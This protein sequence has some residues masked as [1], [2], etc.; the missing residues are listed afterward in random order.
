[1]T[2]KGYKQYKV[3]RKE[4]LRNNMSEL[5]VALADIEERLDVIYRLK[6][7]YGDSEELVL[8]YRDDAI[9][10]L[11]EMGFLDQDSEKLSL[12]FVFK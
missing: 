8:K 2:A 10:E 1:M 3:L 6:K 7:K 9:K 11:D 4:S 5:E 12:D